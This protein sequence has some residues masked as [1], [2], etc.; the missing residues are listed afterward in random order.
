MLESRVFSSSASIILSA[1]FFLLIQTKHWLS[2]LGRALPGP[3][4]SAVTHRASCASTAQSNT[5]E[6]ASG[7]VRV[8]NW[9][10]LCQGHGDTSVLSLPVSL[11]A[12]EGLRYQVQ[13]LG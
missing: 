5:V 9:S 10:H 7:R 12:R 8:I 11:M 13:S 3:A 4:R 6:Q 2:A 1:L